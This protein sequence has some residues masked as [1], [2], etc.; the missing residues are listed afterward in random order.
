MDQQP[1][2]VRA[3]KQMTGEMRA[4]IS[5]RACDEDFHR[6]DELRRDD[7]RF[8]ALPQAEFLAKPAPDVSVL[9]TRES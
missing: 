1:Q 4:E 3:A 8:L 9:P 7:A 2:F 5:C 6:G